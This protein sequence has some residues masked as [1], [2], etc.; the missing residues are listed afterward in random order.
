VSRFIELRDAPVSSRISSTESDFF[1][2]KA[3][4]IFASRTGMLGWPKVILYSAAARLMLSAN[5]PPTA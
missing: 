5:C 1:S 4:T 3:E 2:D